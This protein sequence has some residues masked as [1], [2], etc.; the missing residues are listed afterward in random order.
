VKVP[1]EYF[2]AVIN[3]FQRRHNWTIERDWMQYTT[4]VVPALSA[5]IKALTRPGDK[6]AMHTPIYNCFFSSIVN[7]ACRVKQ[8]PLHYENTTY[9]I[10]FD[11]FDRQLG[12]SD[13]KI[14]LLC[15]P[16]NPAGRVWT[17]EELRAIGE[18]CLRHNVLVV[19]DEIHCE[20]TSPGFKYTPYGTLG[21]DLL[22]NAVIMNA[23]SKAFNIAGLKMAN[24]ICN[25]AAR[26]EAI[27][28]AININEICDVNPF[29]WIA[30]MTAYNECADWMDQLNEYIW[31][32]YL[33]LK[34]QF[35]T[36]LPHLR[37]LPLEGT[38]L[39]WVDCKALG[40]TSEQIG[41]QLLEKANVRIS[42]GT[43]YGDAGEGFIRINLAT[44]RAKLQEAITR[45]IPVLRL[46]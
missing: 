3:W 28:R 14:Y 16:H 2:Q 32:N 1:E 40:L 12:D 11:D 15:N 25:N 38:Y 45:M 31:G 21:K 7:N 17:P 34:E 41:Q 36:N 18:C 39:P 9:S 29:G 33:L 44:Q 22:D 13:V 42:P 24:I 4:G 20:F 19:V 10:D 46:H 35:A 6:V 23:A 37:I 8:I 43:L 26:R 27:D 5:V 30:A